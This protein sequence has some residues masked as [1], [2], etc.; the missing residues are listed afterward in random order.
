VK[1]LPQDPPSGEGNPKKS[2]SLIN[3]QGGRDKVNLLIFLGS[4]R[5]KEKAS[6]RRLALSR[7]GFVQGASVVGSQQASTTTVEGQATLKEQPGRHI[8]L[9]AKIHM[10]STSEAEKTYDGSLPGEYT[11]NSGR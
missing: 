5:S 10:R 8:A 1:V 2:A 3:A 6:H 7:L 11:P 4:H 9:I